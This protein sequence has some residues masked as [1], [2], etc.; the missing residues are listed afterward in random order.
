MLTQ[1]QLVPRQIADA[2]KEPLAEDA[3]WDLL[4]KAGEIIVA[5]GKQ[6]LAFNPRRDSRAA[7][8][9]EALGRSGTLRAPT[10]KVGDRLVV[11]Y[12][13]A[14]YAHLFPR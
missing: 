14:L 10:L 8:L 9:A 11:G 4:A 7:I 13:E 2:R 6:Q 12:G 1:H 5:K 3:A